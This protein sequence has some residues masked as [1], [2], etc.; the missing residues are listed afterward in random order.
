MKRFNIT[1]TRVGSKTIN[2]ESKE[3]ALM[4]AGYMSTDDFEWTDVEITDCQEEE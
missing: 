4:I 1:V 3:E 2:A